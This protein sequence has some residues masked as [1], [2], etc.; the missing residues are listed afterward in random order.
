MEHWS[1]QTASVYGYPSS[2]N[3]RLDLDSDRI[4]LVIVEYLRASQANDA[5]YIATETKSE[6]KNYMY[7]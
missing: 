2:Y 1:Y 3:T 5:S 7:T 4:W 6:F